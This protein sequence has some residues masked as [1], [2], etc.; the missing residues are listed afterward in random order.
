MTPAAPQTSTRRAAGIVGLAV[1]ASRLFGLVREVVFAAMFGAGELLDVY[2]A[3]FRIPNLLRD[4][5]AEGA[6]S[7][8]FTTL[9]TRTWEREGDRPA[10][11]LASLILTAMIF[12]MGALCVVAVIFAPVLVEATNFGFHHVPGKFELAVQ[13]T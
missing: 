3:A 2:I 4:L 8:S 9:F 5:F 6:L 1:I 7:I 11:E 12:L 10:W 13:L